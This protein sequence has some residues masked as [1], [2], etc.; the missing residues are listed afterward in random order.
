MVLEASL[1]MQELRLSVLEKPLSVL[2]YS[3]TRR[4]RY[5][6][7]SAQAF[8]EI[9]DALRIA[10]VSA[11]EE[12]IDTLEMKYGEDWEEEATE[13]EL[14][15]ATEAIEVVEKSDPS[16]TGYIADLKERAD[17]LPTIVPT[18]RYNF[19]RSMDFIFD[20]NTSKGNT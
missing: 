1:Q 19:L 10:L 20:G 15:E 6:E 14:E 13:E 2:A 7:Q 17:M 12:I 16:N 4:V 8:R 9:P 5:Y 18:G 11:A 3:L